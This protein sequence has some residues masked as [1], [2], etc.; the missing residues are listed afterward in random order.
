MT[1]LLCVTLGLTDGSLM[2][3]G[4]QFFFTCPSQN[5]VSRVLLLDPSLN[6]FSNLVTPALAFLVPTSSFEL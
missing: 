6:G 5:A 1:S 2:V 3:S 4:E